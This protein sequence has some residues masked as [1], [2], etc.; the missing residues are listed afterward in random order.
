MLLQFFPVVA[1][2]FEFPL[3]SNALTAGESVNGE[4]SEIEITEYPDVS[5]ICLDVFRKLLHVILTFCPD[6]LRAGR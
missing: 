3:V 2:V 5:I 4:F 1:S 6:R